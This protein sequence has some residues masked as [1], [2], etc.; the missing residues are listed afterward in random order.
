MNE[1]QTFDQYLKEQLS[2]ADYDNLPT[3]LTIT[4]NKWTR[5]LDNPGRIE[6][7]M[8]NELMSLLEHTDE[9]AFDLVEDFGVGIDKLT[10]RQYKELMIA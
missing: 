3:I 6:Y 9:S 1:K 10:V 8:L 7:W 5:R 2:S 4:P